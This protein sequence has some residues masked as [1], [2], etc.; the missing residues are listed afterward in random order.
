[1]SVCKQ[2]VKGD[3]E[4]VQEYKSSTLHLCE[5]FLPLKYQP[6]VLSQ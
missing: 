4:M 5:V 6:L 2:L 3:N 1:M